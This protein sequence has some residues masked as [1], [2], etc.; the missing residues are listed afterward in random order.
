MRSASVVVGEVRFTV[1]RGGR[2]RGR[3][4]AREGARALG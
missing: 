1:S 4:G 3:E 2:E